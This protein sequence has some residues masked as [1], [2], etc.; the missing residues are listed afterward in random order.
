MKKKLLTLLVVLA[1]ALSLAFPSVALAHGGN[2]SLA[3]EWSEHG[4]SSSA[5]VVGGLVVFGG[6]AFVVIRRR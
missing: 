2:E 4:L 6:A 5:L 1:L 3:E